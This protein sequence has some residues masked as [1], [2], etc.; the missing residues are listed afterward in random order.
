MFAKKVNKQTNKQTNS[1]SLY[2][3]GGVRWSEVCKLLL[4]LFA[5]PFPRQCSLNMKKN[6]YAIRLDTCV[7]ELCVVLISCI[8]RVIQFVCSCIVCVC[9]CVCSRQCVPHTNTKCFRRIYVNYHDIHFFSFS[10]LFFFCLIYSTHIRLANTFRSL[11][12]TRSINICVERISPGFCFSRC[13][14]PTL[15]CVLCNFSFINLN[16]GSFSSK[17]FKKKKLLS[18]K[19]KSKIQWEKKRGI[20]SWFNYLDTSAKFRCIRNGHNKWKYTVFDNWSGWLNA[21]LTT[22]FMHF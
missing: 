2:E 4:S 5:S 13:C 6:K 7:V 16:S 10:F 14:F 9:V 12:I 17:Y 21:Y 18:C 8:R 22:Q 15:Q 19:H 11:F 1:V 3:L 20:T